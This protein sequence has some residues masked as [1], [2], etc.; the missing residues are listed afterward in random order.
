M[1][2]NTS[3]FKKLFLEYAE[4]IKYVMKNSFYINKERNIIK[5]SKKRKIY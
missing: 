2:K 5:K 1:K 3:K 4:N